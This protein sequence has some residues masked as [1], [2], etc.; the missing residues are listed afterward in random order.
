MTPSESKNDIV[1]FFPRVGMIA[2]GYFL[3]GGLGLLLA[4]PPG[5]ATPVWPASGIALGLILFW[6]NRYWPGVVLG[7]FLVNALISGD[8]ATVFSSPKN[9]MLPLLI[10][11]GAALHAVVSAILIKWVSAPPWRMDGIDQILKVSFIGGPL[12]CVISASAG[13]L[14]LRSFGVVTPDAVFGTW[15]VWWV[16]D[17]L[18][19]LMFT[20]LTLILAQGE[21]AGNLA[22]KI[23]ILVPLLVISA[24]VILLVFEIQK[25]NKRDLEIRLLRDFE[26]FETSLLLE[27]NNNEKVLQATENLFHASERVSESEFKSFVTALSE[28]MKGL[29]N[30]MWAPLVTHGDRAAFEASLSDELG[31][32]TRIQMV[33]EAGNLVPAVPASM[34]VP[35]AFSRS[36]AH[37]NAAPGFDFYSLPAIRRAVDA[38]LSRRVPVTAAAPMVVNEDETRSL[39]LVFWP[40]VGEDADATQVRGFVVAL[41]DMGAILEMVRSQLGLSDNVIAVFNSGS[42]TLIYQVRGSGVSIEANR[43]DAFRAELGLSLESAFRFGGASETLVMGYP[44]IYLTEVVHAGSWTLLTGGLLFSGLLSLFVLLITGQNMLISRQVEEKTEHMR[45]I[46]EK[47]IEND[48]FLNS[49][50]EALPIMLFAKDAEDLRFVRVNRAAEKLLGMKREEL[51]GKTDYDFFPEKEAAFFQANDRQVLN[52]LGHKTITKEP[53]HTPHGVRWLRTTKVAVKDPS[54]RPRFLL[55]ISEDLTDR[56]K[57]KEELETIYRAFPDLYIWLNS[58]GGVLGY[59]APTNEMVHPLPDGGDQKPIFDL[60]E[61][62]VAAVFEDAVA[63]LSRG[64]T[65]VVIEYGLKRVADTAYFE[66]RCLPLSEGRILMIVRDITEMRITKDRLKLEKERAESASRAKS[67]FLANMSH[68]IRTPI[69]ALIGMTELV[70]DTELNPDQREQLE[71]VSESAESLL[72][73]LNDILDFSKIEVGKLS[74]EMMPFDLKDTLARVVKMHELRAFQKGLKLPADIDAEIPPK[75]VGDANRLRQILVNLIGNALKFTDSGYVALSAKVVAREKHGV[76]VRF[77]VA[78][79]GI[80]IPPEKQSHIFEAFNQ[81]DGST[82]RLYGGT[83]L[84]LTISARLVRMMGGEVSLQ[85]TAG[86]GSCF[87]FELWF[88]EEPG[89][90]VFA[91]EMVAGAG[92]VDPTGFG[93]TLKILVAEDNAVNQKLISRILDKMGHVVVLANNGNQALAL[94][95]EEPFDVVLMDIQMPLMDG[96]QATAAIRA[97]EKISGG[98]IPIVAATAHAMKGD[99]ERCL[100]AGMDGYISKPFKRE[101]IRETLAAMVETYLS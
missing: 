10:G 13:T 4:V 25:L 12:G 57:T 95:K 15:F 49:L 8:P 2:A 81:A 1:K 91:E 5:Y 35:L 7:S 93:R 22:R 89:A 45:A 66:A 85:S 43:L 3:F 48:L 83:G 9:F 37:G 67:E 84:G 55:G 56:M 36:E 41:L 87:S 39:S 34:Y 75:L 53:I 29:Q 20:P 24:L 86:E 73:L 30:L 100:E 62:R 80:G 51:M 44:E 14:L 88:K 92:T 90:Q 79:S 97:Y 77:K 82:T 59:L 40:V 70:L 17:L 32:E 69:N 47:L 27:K 28:D 63:R 94:F 50:V 16:G 31:K 72:F 46:N 61:P 26:A 21:V 68:E 76:R 23:Q 78:D 58:E 71:I 42:G 64:E 54:G 33:D 6:G 74:L 19:V 65:V 52:E 60:F 99:K 38:A 98:H 11:M 18:G 96:Y 101:Q